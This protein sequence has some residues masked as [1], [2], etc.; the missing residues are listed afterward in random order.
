MSYYE[1]WRV[2]RSTNLPL[3]SILLSW[4]SSY[5]LASLSSWA[6]FE[7]CRYQIGP[8]S[9]SGPTGPDIAASNSPINI[10]K[11]EKKHGKYICR[12][13]NE[14]WRD[15]HRVTPLYRLLQDNYFQ[16]KIFIATLILYTLQKDLINRGFHK[17]STIQEWQYCQL[18][19]GFAIRSEQHQWRL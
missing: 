14:S 19:V 6:A 5:R 17:L 7:L 1:P 15:C 9:P 12:L 11:N 13:T 2:W 16:M 4:T 3:S 18:C 8:R 10:P